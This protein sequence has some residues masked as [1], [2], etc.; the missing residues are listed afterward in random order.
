M[1]LT[2]TIPHSKLSKRHNALS[3][4]KTREAVAAGIVKYY[5]IQGETNPADIVSK[6]WKM[7]SVWDTLKILMF[8]DSCKKN[9]EEID[10]E[11][12]SQEQ[13]QAE[14]KKQRMV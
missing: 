9:K 7:A 13:S 11:S 6:H 8:Y 10:K 12:D 4:H 14:T 5:H 2:S 3:Y 1:V